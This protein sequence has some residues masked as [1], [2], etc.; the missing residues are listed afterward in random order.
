MI[1]KNAITSQKIADLL[2]K[3][4]SPRSFNKSIEITKEQM[5]SIAEAARWTASSSN[6][7]PWNI[8]FVNRDIDENSYNKVF[9]SL[10]IGN[11]K[12]CINA[13]VFIVVVARDYFNVNESYNKWAGFDVG[14]AA[15]S[16][17]LQAK[18][19][20]LV[21][22]PLGGFDEQSIK[23][24]FNLPSNHTAYSVI[25]LGYQDTEDKLEEPFITREKAERVRKPLNDNFFLQEW[26]KG[27]ES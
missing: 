5:I 1:Q 6:E 26:G 13:N 12:W 18:E 21:T 3:R 15:T 24:S 25:A 11:Q 16:M 20:G 7:Q 10:S 17:M 14:A 23:D 9:E 4:W 22:H 27:I 19:L 8:L 2:A